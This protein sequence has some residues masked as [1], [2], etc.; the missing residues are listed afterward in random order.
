[1]KTRYITIEREYG[2]GGT[3]I[4]RLLSQ[5][6]GIPCYGREILERVS[7]KLGVS[8]DEIQNR[9]EN[10]TASLL[11]IVYLMGKVNSG[12]NDMLSG[13]G[14]VFVAEQE[15]IRRLAASGKGIF[16]GHSAGEALKDFP[17]VVKVFIRC[18]DVNLK[19][20]HIVQQYGVAQDKAEE[21][22]KRFDRKRAH[23]YQCTSGMRWGDA[24][25]Y[26]IVLDSAT[27]GIDGCAAVL[28]LKPD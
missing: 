17:G 25:L 4:A 14:A 11:Y 20:S 22:R 21:V 1:M 5:E 6:T 12:D 16:V 9:E 27:L 15:E 28:I 10:M 3:E 18:S 23:Y 13:D 26:D 24:N 2:S 7:E 8:V 19:N